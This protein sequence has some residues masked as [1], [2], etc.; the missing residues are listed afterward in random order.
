MGNSHSNTSRGRGKKKTSQGGSTTG[1]AAITFVGARDR[2]NFTHSMLAQT[3]HTASSLHTS[4]HSVLIGTGKQLGLVASDPSP[5]W[6]VEVW[7]NLSEAAPSKGTNT[8]LSHGEIT[9][10][11]HDEAFILVLPCHSLTATMR[12][13]GSR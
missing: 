1:P 11:D 9:S 10:D 4:H 7:V 5:G 3:L 12:H 8:I 2:Y 6:T 13:H